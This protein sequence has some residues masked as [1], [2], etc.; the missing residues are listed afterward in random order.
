MTKTRL[1]IFTLVFALLLSAASLFGVSAKDVWAEPASCPYKYDY[2]A[3]ITRLLDFDI[4]N[5][6]EVYE[7]Y[8]APDEVTPDEATPD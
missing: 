6:G 3:E 8:A 7:H 4:C 5:Y 2:K 1:L